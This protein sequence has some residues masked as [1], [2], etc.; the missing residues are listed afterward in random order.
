MYHQSNLPLVVPF[1]KKYCLWEININ[2]LSLMLGHGGG[3]EVGSL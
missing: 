2:F 1:S 3:L